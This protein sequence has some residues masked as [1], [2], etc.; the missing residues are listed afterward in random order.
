VAGD[1]QSK[2]SEAVPP[3]DPRASTPAGQAGDDFQQIQGVGA[4]IDR[5]LH[6]AGILTYQDLAALSPEQIAAGLAGVAGL[7][8]AR[9]ASQDWPG[10]AGRLAGPAA[11]PLPSEP[12]QRYASFHI[13]FLLDVDDSVR[14][15]KVHHHQS[16]T[17]EAWA[18]WDEDRLLALLRDHIPHM[19]ARQPA[20]AADIPSSAAPPAAEP[21]TAVPSEAQL[22]RVTASGD[23]PDGAV[24]SGDQPAEAIPL[25]GQEETTDLPVGLPSSS[26]RIDYLSLTREGQRSRTWA[27]GEPTSIGFTLQVGRTGTRE[28][29]ALDFT[30]NVTA[31]SVLG[32][33]Q[34]WPLGTVQGAVRVDEPLSVELTGEPLPRGLYRPEATVLI[35]PTDH[36]PDSEPLQGRRAS[37]AL[38][39][40]A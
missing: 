12:D 19:T 15:T 32:D 20:E 33:D 25:G 13:E 26:L 35:Y 3:R 29:A 7:S 36:A 18:G 37:G 8:P 34:R 28:A 2:R 4:A 38:I 27:P 21:E 14:R 6:D 1:H 9:I 23:Q 5:R 11:P 31:S 30:A 24:P 10:Q 39:Q 16:G 22:D 17:D 40:V